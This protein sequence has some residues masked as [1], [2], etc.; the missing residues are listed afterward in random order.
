MT[1]HVYLVVQANDD[2]IAIR[3]LMKRPAGRQP[4]FVN[5]LE[6]PR[7]SLWE[8][9]YEIS[10]FDTDADLLAG[11]RYLGLNPLKAGMVDRAEPYKWSSYSPYVSA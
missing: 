9:R 6:K 5:V 7:D 3:N 1:N 10:P 4:R 11:C 2:V 8:G